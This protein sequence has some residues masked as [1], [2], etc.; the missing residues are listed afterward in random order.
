M[1]MTMNTA[2][3][4]AVFSI[5]LLMSCSGD[6][7]SSATEPAGGASGSAASDGGNATS[8]S[9]TSA[10]TGGTTGSG[11]AGGSAVEAP[12]IQYFGRWDM[13]DPANPS[14]SWGPI[15]VKAKFEGT[16][17]RIKL[18]DPM[19]TFTYSIDGG[20][21][22][23]LPASA[24]AERSIA[25][26][27]VDGMHT[28]EFFR[29]S[30]GGYGKTVIGGLLLDPGKHLLAPNARPPR[31]IE[32]VG[33]SISAG[34]ADEGMNPSTPQNENGYM[35]YGPQL[36]RM[37]DA[38]WSVIAHSGQGMYRNLCEQLPPM[39]LHMPDEFKMTHHPFAGG[40][41][42]DF[43]KW[44]P[45]VLIVT[46]G[47]NDFADYPAGSCTPPND[48]AFIDAYKNF[49][50]FARSQYMDAHI[51]AVGTFVALVSNPFGKC[52]ADICNAVAMLNDKK[53]H[54]VD[55]SSPIMWLTGPGDY[56]GDW[57]HP[58]VAAHTKIATRL[59]DIIRPILGW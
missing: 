18:N 22:K 33:D 11:G 56:V 3:R 13:S 7:P 25:S 28:L 45:D 26:G 19:N 37:L 59:R 16:S 2:S 6:G 50:T 36:A 1:H 20:E 35:A 12:G 24:Q 32:V 41:H 58:T 5:G 46:L 31:K 55:P 15:G 21:M 4:V 34:Y 49:L 39:S 48:A 30:E 54:C 10:G 23:T 17:V 27:L 42:W 8:G 40:G 53:M 47:T 43:G 44:K 52:N 57:T 14:G 51:F 29:R 9:S 38:E